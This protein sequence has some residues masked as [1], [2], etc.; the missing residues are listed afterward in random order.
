M[1]IASLSDSCDRCLSFITAWQG[2][3][4]TLLSVLEFFSKIS[5]VN[6]FSTVYY[7]SGIQQTT[8]VS[9]KS[10]NQAKAGELTACQ[11]AKPIGTVT[12]I[13]NLIRMAPI[14]LF[15][16]CTFPTYLLYVRKVVMEK[17]NFQFFNGVVQRHS[18]KTRDSSVNCMQR[19]HVI[20]L[21]SHHA[22]W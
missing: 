16:F 22:H 7:H 12:C 19:L 21:L 8:G 13:V 2:R 1:T 4:R 20:A 18:E 6:V 5:K 10:T 11:H 3:G 17:Q 14:L 9:V 15:L